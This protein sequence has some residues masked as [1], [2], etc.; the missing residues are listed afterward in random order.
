MIRTQ[1]KIKTPRII[2][3]LKSFTIYLITNYGFVAGIVP[4]FAGVV[5]CF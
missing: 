1:F 5:L 2:A 3:R 4:V